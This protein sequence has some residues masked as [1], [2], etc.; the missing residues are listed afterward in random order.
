MPYGERDFVTAG[1]H[2]MAKGKIK[3]LVHLSQ[4]TYRPNT[5][6]VPDHN[7]KGYGLIEAEDGRDVY[8]P[9]EAVE[10]RR[11]FDDLRRGQVVEYTL[12]NGPYLRANLVRL[13]SAAPGNVHRPAA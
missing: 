5:R 4:Q 9:H 8:F 12:E 2:I 3:K 6:L 13:T 7:D 10:G 1:D 11:G